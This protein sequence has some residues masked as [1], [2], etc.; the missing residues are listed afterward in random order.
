MA[1]SATGESVLERVVRILEVFDSDT[2]TVTVTE[3]ATRANLPLS[4]AS[5]LVDEMAQHGLLRRDATHQIRIGLRLWELGTRASPTRSLRDAA[6]PFMQDLHAVVGHHVQLG[7]REGDEVLF[8]ERLSAP[9][10]VINLTRIAGR[11]P[12]CA[13]SSGLILLAHAPAAVQNRIMASPLT[14]YTNHTIGEPGELRRFL[15]QARYTGVACCR[16]FIHPAATG[17][18]VPVRDSRDRVVAALSVIV[19]TD[20]HE[21]SRI[22]ALQAAALGIHR[23][24]ARPSRGVEIP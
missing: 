17:I 18:A 21:S 4:T 14:V 12:L 9:V 8:L 5:R 2:M 11:L 10:A 7:V 20:G 15:A 6:M 22:P 13:S 23:A 24:I 3:V 19:P 16:G 1:R